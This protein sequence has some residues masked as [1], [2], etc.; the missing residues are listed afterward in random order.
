L[1]YTRVL[2]VCVIRLPAIVKLIARGFFNFPYGVF[3]G[4]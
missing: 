2:A 3:D 1:S 4:L